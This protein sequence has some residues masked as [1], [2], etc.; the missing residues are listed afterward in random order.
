MA[1]QSKHAFG[2]RES[3]DAAIAEGKIDA[4]DV[5]FVKDAEGKPFIGWVD[6]NGEQVICENTAEFEALEEEIAKKPNLTVVEQ[7]IETAI[8]E[9]GAGIEVIEF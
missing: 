6:S 4:Y 3:I 9:S 1:K 8:A 2:A 5:L 7:M